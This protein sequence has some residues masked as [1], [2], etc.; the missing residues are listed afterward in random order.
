MSIRAA[1]S[2]TL[3]LLSAGCAATLET[4]VTAFHQLSNGLQGQRFVMMPT[5]EQRGSLE[6]DNYAR[7]VRE[8]L[9]G[10]GL[11]DADAS[12]GT[13]NGTGSASADLGV[14]IAYGIAGGNATSRVGTD[15]YAGFGFGSGGFSMGSVGIGIGFPI[16]S[17]GA[18]PGDT[19]AYQ[20][21]LRVEIDRQDGA[22]T[23]PL[24]PAPGANARGARVFEARATSEGPS[25]S[26]APVMR[27]MVQAVFEEFPGPS[28]KTRVVRTPLEET[29]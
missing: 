24:N 19:L 23:S 12:K 6:F 11:V 25:A 17:S 16:G 20:R 15:G 26:L 5:A 1:L 4:Q 2:V 14:A 27:A 7:L 10:K 8:A 9:V 13:G 3:A 29:Q 21:T 28:G 18:G 22:G